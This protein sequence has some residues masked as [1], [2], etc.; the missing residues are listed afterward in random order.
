MGNAIVIQNMGGRSMVDKG[1]DN[2]NFVLRAISTDDL[3]KNIN[4]VFITNHPDKGGRLVAVCTDGR[5]LHIGDM[6]MHDGVESGLY[7]VTSKSKQAIVL[8]KD[9]VGYEF[10][11]YKRVMMDHD[12]W[13]WLSE[14]KNKDGD[15]SMF[16]RAVYKRGSYNEKYIQDAYINGQKHATC[17]DVRTY[18]K[19]NTSILTVVE[20]CDGM[21]K[22]EQ[23]YNEKYAIVMGLV[24]HGDDWEKEKVVPEV[25]VEAEAVPEVVPETIP[26]P[27]PVVPE[28]PPNPDPAWAVS[29]VP[30]G[31][32]RVEA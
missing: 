30:V 19:G 25:E 8:E 9:D 1:F 22:D 27:P 16:F 15:K 21:D 32:D 29:N 11:D 5:R 2:L 14:V 12:A 23:P 28:P 26:D 31:W 4:H 6:G 10:P 24:M 13:D 17:V 18:L 3:R 7:R 20:K